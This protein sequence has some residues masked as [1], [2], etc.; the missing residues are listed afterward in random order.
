VSFHNL[1]GRTISSSVSSVT[2]PWHCA[3]TE[4]ESIDDGLTLAASHAARNAR[5][6]AAHQ[7]SGS[8]SLTGGF[9]GGCGADPRPRNAPV[10]ASLSSIVHD[11]VDESI[12]AT[13]AIWL[14]P[15]FF[16]GRQPP[17]RPAAGYT[18]LANLTP[19]TSP[20]SN[21][22]SYETKWPTED[23]TYGAG[24]C[25]LDCTPVLR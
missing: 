5:V 24:S 4:I 23:G 11:W 12:P 19:D 6:N 3:S 8:C 15:I 18:S 14:D 1:A 2:I 10:S 16:E 13:I 22:C 7:V 25:R 9:V 17:R 21:G 20:E